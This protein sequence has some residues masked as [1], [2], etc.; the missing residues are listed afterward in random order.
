VGFHIQEAYGQTECTGVSNINRA[1]RLKFGTVGPNLPGV[2]VKIAEDGEILVRG[3]GVFL[4]Y[5]NAPEATAEAMVDGWLC[6][7]DIGEF[8]EEKHLRITDR[9]K[10]IIVTAGGKNVAPQNL[11]NMLKPYRGISQVV[12][13][14]DKRKFLSALVTLDYEEMALALDEHL[15]SLEACTSHPSVLAQIQS[16]IDAVNAELPS[17]ETIKKFRLLE[18][19]FSIDDGELTPTLKIKRRVVQK[20]YESLIDGMYQEKFE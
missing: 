17:Y 11:E 6:T 18:R 5:F 16:Y 19:D 12:V 10:D 20:Q 4:G 13:V 14:G 1:H 2:E 15:P 7:G 3:D 9:K 8:D